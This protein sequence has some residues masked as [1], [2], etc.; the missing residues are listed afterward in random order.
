M[1][2]FFGL[3]LL[4]GLLSET[5]R[6]QDW[7]NRK[8][9]NL[10]ETHYRFGSLVFGGGDVLIPLMYEQYV[11]R[12]EAPRVKERNPNVIRMEKDHFLTGAGM[13]RAIPGPVFSIASYVGGLG[14]SPQGRA[15]QVIGCVVGTIA[16][17][18][19][20]FLLVIFF[21][22][23]WNNLHRY[24]LINRALRGINASVVG[25]MAASTVYLMK[26]I[27]LLGVTAGSMSSIFNVAVI[28]GTMYVLGFTRLPAPYVA[29]A[30]LFLGWA[31]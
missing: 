2:W 7:E 20:S 13:V 27:S 28:L 9:F 29:A 8:I 17:F 10:F 1:L 4:G 25:I 19:P 15:M 12:P 22:P 31:V 5:A 14:L 23:L 11:V 26:D 16:I 18:L 30:C 6:K 24:E 21:Y 3:F